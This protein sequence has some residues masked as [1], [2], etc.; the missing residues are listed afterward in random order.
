MIHPMWATFYA[1]M[2]PIIY[3]QS[4]AREGETYDSLIKRV[5]AN[6]GVVADMACREYDTR[7]KGSSHP[8][9]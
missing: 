8:Y 2:W 3:E 6:C 1:A 7:D 9:R 5:C 4:N